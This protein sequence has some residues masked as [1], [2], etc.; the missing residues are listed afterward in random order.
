MPTD[1]FATAVPVVTD[2]DCYLGYLWQGVVFTQRSNGNDFEPA[3][4]TNELY[5]SPTYAAEM[6]EDMADSHGIIAAREMN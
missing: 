6:A 1:Y 3:Y 5:Y 2:D 4:K